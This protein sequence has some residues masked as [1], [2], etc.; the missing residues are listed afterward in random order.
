[1]FGIVG[2]I[3]TASMYVFMYVCVCSVPVLSVLGKG[4][5]WT[6]PHTKDPK[7]VYKQEIQHTE[8]LNS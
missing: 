5:R 8:R 7:N 2:F 3:P 4:L 6:D 1:M